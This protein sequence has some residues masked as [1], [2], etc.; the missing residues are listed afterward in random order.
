MIRAVIHIEYDRAFGETIDVLS[1][2][3]PLK[4]EREGA[5]CYF[6]CPQAGSADDV[7]E[8]FEGVETQLF[9][10]FITCGKEAE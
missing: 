3:C 1:P 5:P 7:C 4:E 8:H 2:D 10:G 9:V 6:V